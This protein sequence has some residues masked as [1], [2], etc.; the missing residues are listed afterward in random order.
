MLERTEGAEPT[1][2]TVAIAIQWCKT[3]VVSSTSR[4]FFAAFN[5][6]LNSK[7]DPSQPPEAVFEAQ[8]QLTVQLLSN[9]NQLMQDDLTTRAINGMNL[10]LLVGTN[11]LDSTSLLTHRHTPSNFGHPCLVRIT[12]RF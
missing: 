1:A 12:V 4:L 3:G 11:F 6:L 10:V 2:Y 7:D 8:K 9:I 5:L